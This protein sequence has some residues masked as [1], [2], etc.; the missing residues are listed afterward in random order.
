MPLQ[1]RRGVSGSPMLGATNP[2]QQHYDR[3]FGRK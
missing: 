1:L 3:M 2:Q